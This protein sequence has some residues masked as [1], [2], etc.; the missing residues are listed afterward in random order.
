MIGSDFSEISF[1]RWLLIAIFMTLLLAM[2]CRQEEPEVVEET[3]VPPTSTPIPTDI[4]ATPEPTATIDVAFLPSPTPLATEVSVQRVASSNTATPQTYSDPNLGVTFQFNPAWKLTITPEEAWQRLTLSQDG[5]EV[6]IRFQ[7][8]P[9]VIPTC[10]GLL[11]ESNVDNFWKDNLPIGETWRAKAEMGFSNS[12]QDADLVFIDIVWPEIESE[13]PIRGTMACNLAL[14]HLLLGISYLLPVNVSELSDGDYEQQLLAEM[15]QI[16]ASLTVDEPVTDVS[17]ERPEELGMEGMAFVN[18]PRPCLVWNDFVA[19]ENGYQITVRF[20]PTEE[21]F[22]YILPVDSEQ[23]LLPAYIA[24]AIDTVDLPCR[25]QNYQVEILAL[26]TATFGNQIVADRRGSAACML[27]REEAAAETAAEPCTPPSNLEESR[28]S[29]ASGDCVV[30]I[31]SY[32]DETGFEI[33]L[34]YPRSDETFVYL[35]PAN[36]TEFIVPE[37]DRPNLEASLA[38]CNRRKDMELT[39]TALGENERRVGSVFMIVECAGFAPP[40]TPY[41]NGLLNRLEFEEE[42]E[43]EF[44]LS[45]WE[46]GYRSSDQCDDGPYRWLNETHLLLFPIVNYTAVFEDERGGQVTQ[47]VVLNVVTGQRWVSSQQATDGCSLPIYSAELNALIEST[48]GMVWLRQLDGALIERH[49]GGNPLHLGDTGTRLLAGNRWV[50]LESGETVTLPIDDLNRLKQVAWTDD[51]TRFYACCALYGDVEADIL[52]QTDVIDDIFPGGIGVGPAYPG[53]LTQWLGDGRYVMHNPGAVTWT[54][55]NGDDVALVDGTPVTPTLPLIDPVNQSYL[56]LGFELG[57]NQTFDC[58]WTYQLRPSYDQVWLQNCERGLLVD[59]PSLETTELKGVQLA[60]WSPNGEFALMITG[61]Q[62]A[63]YN[64][65]NDTLTDLP[66]VPASAGEITWSADGSYAALL[67]RG[68][69]LIE[70]RTGQSRNL[71]NISSEGQ[72]AWRPNSDT[73]AIATR[74]RS[75]RY[76]SFANGLGSGITAVNA[77]IRVLRWSPDGTYLALIADNDLLVIQPDG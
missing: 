64:P 47:P 7:P 48:D 49:E 52:T 36:S 18:E 58:L 28:I 16:V 35:V 68:L 55:I 1:K 54:N 11:T 30:W 63:L 50:D 26:R 34:H 10:S 59:V 37:E 45:G 20:E 9:D 38:Q 6:Q 66:N 41:T 27:A 71:S 44:R 62:Y 70:T 76:V 46:E 2:G 40:T 15:D 56:N 61:T 51:D 19:D 67:G 31:D 60:S 65:L 74:D 43:N 72:M 5:Y 22:Q 21:L 33:R 8:R 3:A 77:D 29:L 23:F 42:N 24:P 73:L 14:D 25:R 53:E 32:E 75:V 17:C 39:V 57:L 69:I 13:D 12:Y 4:P